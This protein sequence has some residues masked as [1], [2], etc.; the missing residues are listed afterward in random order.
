MGQS[1]VAS[2]KH[3]F[4]VLADRDCSVQPKSQTATFRLKTDVLCDYDTKV[5]TVFYNGTQTT[6]FMVM[7]LRS[8]TFVSNLP[9]IL[10]AFNSIPFLMPLFQTLQME[11]YAS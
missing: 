8:I 11:Q 10:A 6:V 9:Y 7:A 1:C 3:Q 2:N 4:S 5:R